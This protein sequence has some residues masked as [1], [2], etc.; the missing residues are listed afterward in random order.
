MSLSSLSTF[1][2]PNQPCRVVLFDECLQIRQHLDPSSDPIH[3]ILVPGK[4]DMFCVVI[5]NTVF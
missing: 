4:I 2:V 3:V 1:G 5:L